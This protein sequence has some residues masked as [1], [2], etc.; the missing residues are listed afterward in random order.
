M[1]GSAL[2]TALVLLAA[3]LTFSILPGCGKKAPPRLPDEDSFI[4]P[5]GPTA[6]AGLGAGLAAGRLSRP[7]VFLNKQSAKYQPEV[8][9]R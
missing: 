3:V 5:D 7:E 2:K 6:I 9:E 8:T 1:T 4:H